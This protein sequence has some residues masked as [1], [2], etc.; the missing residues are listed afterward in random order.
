MA[1]NPVIY[2][3]E[4][5]RGIERGEAT[6]YEAGGPTREGLGRATGLVRVS[7]IRKVA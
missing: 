4:I 1:N 7:A 2:V 3:E 6:S 5:R